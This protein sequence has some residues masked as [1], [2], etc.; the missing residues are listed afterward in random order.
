[1]PTHRS[2]SIAFALLIAAVAALSA[3]CF[4][5]EDTPAPATTP[6]PTVT[7]EPTTTG[8]PEV[9]TTS[10][11][12]PPLELSRPPL[13][14]GLPEGAI[15]PLAVYRYR[16]TTRNTYEAV[17]Y[18]VGVGRALYSFALPIDTTRELV[19]GRRLVVL[20]REQL[21]SY[22]LD[23][24]DDPLLFEGD[25]HAHIEN[26]RP[27]P[28]GDLIAINVTC[29]PPQECEDFEL[30]NDIYVLHAATGEEVLHLEQ[31]ADLPEDFYGI[32]GPIGWREDGSLVLGGH[33]HRDGGG[34][35]AAIVAPHGEITVI[36]DDPEL[37]LSSAWNRARAW[38]QLVFAERRFC[39]IE[40]YAGTTRIAL[41]DAETREELAAIE[42]DAPVL[43]FWGSDRGSSGV[44]DEILIKELLIDHQERERWREQVAQGECPGAPWDYQRVDPERFWI[45]PLDGSPPFP[46]AG[47][48]E[49][50]RRWDG[51]RL[52]TY[53]CAG[54]ET[55][56]P[57]RFERGAN[58]DCDFRERDVELRIGGVP[59]AAAF[60]VEF[61]GFVEIVAPR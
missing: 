12:T 10:E 1:M 26:V 9:T 61:L 41:V 55:L 21:R 17:V 5:D 29:E 33:F 14:D 57:S 56:D 54:L 47:E 8:T 15:G 51:E 46:I 25:A 6:A 34:G 43:A 3:A 28:E 52:V 53:A 23:G 18:D 36:R 35:D 49:A 50:R 32:A 20:S 37:G 31:T 42:A 16:D 30:P 40:G 58:E 60:Q 4:D 7:S 48:L 45:L 27:S 11:A 2:T 39:G 24:S 22:A 13:V 44:K 38:P 59:I 19:A